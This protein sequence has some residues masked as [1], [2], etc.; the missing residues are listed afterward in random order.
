MAGNDTLAK[1][2]HLIDQKAP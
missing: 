1:G 2:K